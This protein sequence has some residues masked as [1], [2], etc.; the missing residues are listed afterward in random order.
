MQK[1][2]GETEAE[3][4]QYLRA[5]FKTLAISCCLY[6]A[7][8]LLTLIFGKV[9]QFELGVQCAG[10][11]GII[12][13]ILFYYTFLKFGWIF[14]SRFLGVA[15]LGV[16]FSNNVVLGVIVFVLYVFI[17][18]RGISAAPATAFMTRR[19]I[20]AVR[21]TVFMMGRETG[22]LPAAASYISSPMAPM[23]LL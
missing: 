15:T 5:R 17:T 7:A 9:I 14:F 19:G 2:F 11:L 21:A 10:V 20:S 16:L 4:Y 8:G 12:A 13:S 6:A 1:L 22:A 18:R 23:E 3:Q